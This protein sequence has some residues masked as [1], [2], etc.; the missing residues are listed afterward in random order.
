MDEGAGQIRQDVNEIIRTRTAMAEKLE[1]L[2][3]RIQDTVVEAKA[4]VLDV[5]DN[6][7]DTAEDF[8]ERTRRTLDPVYQTQQHPWAMIGAAA[9]AGYLLARL[10]AGESVRGNGALRTGEYP[11]TPEEEAAR[12]VSPIASRVSQWQQAMVEGL[13]DQVQ[14]ELSRVKGAL[15]VVGRTFLRDMAKQALAMLT[16]S[17]ETSPRQ[18]RRPY[19]N[20]QQ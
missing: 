16:E 17:L 18:V 4:A 2:E 20:G 8:V 10:G 11:G 13:T 5:V 14:D 19:P 3:A 15:V 6:V 7:K 12:R 1:Q 9:A